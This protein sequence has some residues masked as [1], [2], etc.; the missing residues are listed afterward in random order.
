MWLHCVWV[1]VLGFSYM[2]GHG[3]L[4]VG[5]VMDVGVADAALRLLCSSVLVPRAARH[6]VEE[7]GGVEWLVNTALSSIQSALKGGALYYNAR[8]GGRGGDT[9]GAVERAVRAMHALH[10]LTTLRSVLHS[11]SSRTTGLG[12]WLTNLFRTRPDP[13]HPSVSV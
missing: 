1:A 11:R 13:F 9:T 3:V 7:A 5:A 8:H 2:I 10:Q 12:A 4:I 6:W